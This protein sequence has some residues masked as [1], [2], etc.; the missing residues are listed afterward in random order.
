VL[1]LSYAEGVIVAKAQQVEK[2]STKYLDLY[3]VY[4]FDVGSPVSIRDL[5]DALLST[6]VGVCALVYIPRSEVEKYRESGWRV[7]PHDPTSWIVPVLYPSQVSEQYIKYFTVRGSVDTQLMDEMYLERSEFARIHLGKV[8]VLRLA[9]SGLDKVGMVLTDRYCPITGYLELLVHESGIFTLTLW[10]PIRGEISST[11]VIDLR[12]RLEIEGSLYSIYKDVLKV[13]ILLRY[14]KEIEL[15]PLPYVVVRDIGGEERY[16]RVADVLEMYA[17]YIRYLVLLKRGSRVSSLTELE[18]N[19][20]NPWNTFFTILFTEVLKGERKF[21]EVLRRYYAQLY[22]MTYLHRG[23][24]PHSIVSRSL[25]S[26][27]ARTVELMDFS[28]GRVR[29]VAPRITLVLSEDE[30][31]IVSVQKR[32]IGR[33]EMGKKLRLL[34]I[35]I[36][37]FLNIVRHLLKTLDYLLTSKKLN[38]IDA[39]TRFREEFSRATDYLSNCFYLKDA[40]SRRLFNHCVKVFRV[41]DL[42]SLV[43]S[44]FESLNYVML[45]RYQDRITKMQLLLTIVFGIFAIPSILFFYWEWFY[46]Y[47]LTGE[48]TAL[49]PVTILSFFPIVPVLAVILYLY[50]KWKKEV[51][52]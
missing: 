13:N 12:Y 22:A 4:S 42:A 16:L 20:R 43:N 31:H 36:M 5:I 25:S 48:S 47:V 40:E 52:M 26:T 24:I 49:L 15:G 19:M 39:L 45:T 30:A 8:K 11:E 9:R 1:K 38:D 34:N 7:L 21:I 2:L 37:E 6:G 35:T 3:Y 23:V 50:R 41:D 18:N 33:G 46:D 44:K 29:R 51:F 14:G 28:R 27:Y 32:Y 10:F 17:N